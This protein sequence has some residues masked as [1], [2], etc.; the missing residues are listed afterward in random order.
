MPVKVCADL[1]QLMFVEHLLC[2]GL[3]CAPS[4]LFLTSPR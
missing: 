1:V 2:G 3:G 4:R